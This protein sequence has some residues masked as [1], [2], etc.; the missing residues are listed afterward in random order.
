MRNLLFFFLFCLLGRMA[1]AQGIVTTPWHAGDNSIAALPM[2]TLA[3][4]G[5]IVDPGFSITV[6]GIAISAIIDSDDVV[7]RYPANWPWTPKSGMRYTWDGDQWVDEFGQPADTTGGIEYP[8]IMAVHDGD[9]YKIK[10]IDPAGEWVRLEGVNC[11]EIISNRINKEQAF[12]RAI[13]DS[14]RLLL[15]GKTVA[16]KT[17]GKDKY[18]RTLVTLT[19]SGRD[20]GEYL[21]EKGWAWYY[22]KNDLDR[23][24]RLKYRKLRDY[25][26]RHRLGLWVNE[27]SD[28]P[29]EHAIDPSEFSAKHH[30]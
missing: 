25:A 23:D 20:L 28:D 10:T 7:T 30:W 24:T 13:G 15:K 29:L 26:K 5:S 11:P 12:G 19:V 27:D 8:R 4:D 21:L 17:Y 22:K 2:V 9:S 3:F 1:L 18:G 16:M 6:P 14:V